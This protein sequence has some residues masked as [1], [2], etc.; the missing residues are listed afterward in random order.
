V[1]S[2]AARIGEQSSGCSIEVLLALSG[3][4]HAEG[5]HRNRKDKI[6]RTADMNMTSTFMAHSLVY[7]PGFARRQKMLATR[8]KIGHD[9]A[10]GHPR[11]GGMES[12][13]LPLKP[14][15]RLM[16][17][18]DWLLNWAF[19]ICACQFGC[20]YRSARPASNS[21]HRNVLVQQSR[22]RVG[23]LDDVA[24]GSC[25]AGIPAISTG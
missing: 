14:P 22:E 24:Q 13:T 6:M 19:W 4:P 25:R 1:I 16:V 18:H 20:E 8:A 21:G 5:I 12:R 9:S 10:G 2:I 23:T 15:S 11:F 17:R 7:G 3:I